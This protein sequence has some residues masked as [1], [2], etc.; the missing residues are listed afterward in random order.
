MSNEVIAIIVAWVLSAGLSIWIIWSNWK[1]AKRDEEEGKP[2]P[3]YP[4]FPGF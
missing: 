2:P 1:Q 3:D 4:I